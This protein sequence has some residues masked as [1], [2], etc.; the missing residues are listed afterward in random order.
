MAKR[1]VNQP[2]VVIAVQEKNMLA[3]KHS[4]SLEWIN[5]INNKNCTEIP[6]DWPSAIDNITGQHVVLSIVVKDI[7][8][9][10]IQPER[11]RV[12]MII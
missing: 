5:W 2:I 4:H 11:N 1:C 3:P 9:D 6:F 12:I 7:T 8:N 10:K